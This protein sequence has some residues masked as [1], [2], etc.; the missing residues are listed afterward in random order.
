MYNITKIALIINLLLSAF[1]TFSQ[2]N[3]IEI[4]GKIMENHCKGKRLKNNNIVIID[5]NGNIDT[6]YAT[7]GKFKLHLEIHNMYNIEFNHS[8]RKS[9]YV[10]INT[11]VSSQQYQYAKY[12]CFNISLPQLD[13]PLLPN[14]IFVKFNHKKLAYEYKLVDPSTYA[15]AN[16]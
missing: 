4:S 16:Q 10:R 14:T 6:L 7:K 11:H 13:T 9:K 2:E 8:D 5:Q 15:L 12:F 1:M 3:I